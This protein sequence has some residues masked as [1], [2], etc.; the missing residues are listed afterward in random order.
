MKSEMKKK[1]QLT[2]QKYKETATNNYMPI[3]WTTQMK[4]K[5]SQKCAIWDFPG[6]PVVKNL[7]SNAGDTSWI[8]GQGTVIP[9]ATGQLSPRATTTELSRLNQSPRATDCRAFWN[10]HITTT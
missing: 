4:W 8:P 3:K 1:L 2:P 9:H 7:P 5:N 10:P 6:G